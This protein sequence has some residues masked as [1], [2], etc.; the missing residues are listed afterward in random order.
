DE[1]RRFAEYDI[2]VRRAGPYKLCIQYSS[3]SDTELWLE[4]SP[5]VPPARVAF[6]STGGFSQ[7]SRRWT[8]GLVLQ[9]PEGPSTVKIYGEAEW[10]RISTLFI[11]RHNL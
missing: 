11:R 10:P 9:L 6:P 5:A 8:K 7:D 4:A 2:E 1:K 3:P